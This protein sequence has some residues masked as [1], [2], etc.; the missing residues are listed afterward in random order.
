MKQTNLAERTVES[1][2]RVF[3]ARCTRYDLEAVRA[4]S[5]RAFEAFGGI[6]SFVRPGQRVLLKPNLLSAKDPSR[7]VTTHPIV[8][9]AIAG[10]IGEAGATPVIGDSPGGAIRGIRR[11][12]TNTGM[13]ELSERTGIEL[14]N[15]EAAGSKAISSG[16]YDFYISRPVLEADVIINLPKLKTHSLTLLTCAVKN[17]FG[18]MPG[19]H[20]GEQH[21]R[22]PKPAEFADMLVHL[23]KLV[24]PAFTIVDGITAM[25]G[26]GPSSGERVDLGLLVA[27][28]DAVAID[29]AV[30]DVVGFRE[31]AIDTTRIAGAMGLGEGDVHRISLIGDDIGSRRSDFALPSNTVHTLIPKPLVRLIA[32]FVWVQPVIDPDRCTG[33][34]FCFESCPVDAIVRDGRVYRID[35]QAC[36]KCLC[37]H[38]LCPD[39]S[40]DI[41]MSRLARLI[42]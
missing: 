32:P 39:S 26:N 36:V 1:T 34:A 2:K 19:F 11:V 35:K 30:A 15:F 38:E 24:A 8:V 16:R 37:C 12:W 6:E 21:K 40:I 5:M 27:G 28:D 17:M 22:Y 14:V 10:L 42:T 20:K 31:G 9:E 18:V 41:T 25:E 7:A 23:F 3:I 13:E 33:C 29:A 4:A